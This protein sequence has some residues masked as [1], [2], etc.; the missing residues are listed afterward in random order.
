MHPP[1]SPI[2]FIKVSRAGNVYMPVLTAMRTTHEC[3]GDSVLRHMQGSNCKSQHCCQDARHQA[4]HQTGSQGRLEQSAYKNTVTIHT[5]TC[6]FQKG[7]T[8]DAKGAKNELNTLAIRHL[9]ACL[10]PQAHLS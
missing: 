4:L 9:A 8:S 3:T 2:A 1:F 5:D 6:V 10:A 7:G